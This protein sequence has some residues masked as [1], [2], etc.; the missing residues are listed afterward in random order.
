MRRVSTITAAPTAPRISS[1]HMNQNRVWPGVPNRYRI[2]SSAIVMR[3]KSIAT[4]VVPLPGTLDASSTPC[5]AEVITASV[6][7]GSISETAPTSVVLPT[8]KPPAMTIFAEVISL[9]CAPA[10]SELAKSTQHPFQQIHPLRE[11]FLGSGTVQR[12]QP[13]G[14]HVG[15]EHPGY[16]QR[17]PAV[18]RDLGQ[19]LRP[20]LAQHGDAVLVMPGEPGFLNG[21]LAGDQDRLDGD[22]A[23]RLRPA[24]GDRIGTDQVAPGVARLSHRAVTSFRSTSAALRGRAGQ[25]WCATASRGA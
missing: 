9:G 25:T 5:P 2:R 4:V 15:D 24:P 13:V 18:G 21:G 17:E 3:P 11:A 16:S 19:R 20:R 1:S 22:V 12:Q 10:R 7:R 14:D 23:T 6:V 8:P